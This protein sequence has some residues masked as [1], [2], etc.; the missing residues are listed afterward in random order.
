MS[1]EMEWRMGMRREQGWI[2]NENL[3]CGQ[4]GNNMGIRYCK[5]IFSLSSISSISSSQTIWMRQAQTLNIEYHGR[6]GNE[7][8]QRHL[9]SRLWLWDNNW[10]SAYER[11]TQFYPYDKPNDM[12][13]LSFAHGKR[14]RCFI[15]RLKSIPESYY[16]Q[17]RK[18]KLDKKGKCT[19]EELYN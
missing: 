13:R 11:Y 7:W 8:Q 9:M 6:K 10:C 12:K 19:R 17:P 14:K 1:K 16:I 5:T 15:Y 4:C 3:E 2:R 18:K